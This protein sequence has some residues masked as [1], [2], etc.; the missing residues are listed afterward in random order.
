[1]EVS[2]AFPLVQSERGVHER[3]QVAWGSLSG[4]VN[5]V[6]RGN[7]TSQLRAVGLGL[8]HAS[9]EYWHLRFCGFAT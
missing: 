9:V 1:M 4:L 5:H 8:F 3:P 6:K 7:E 2:F